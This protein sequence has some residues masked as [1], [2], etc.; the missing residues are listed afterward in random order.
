MNLLHLEDDVS[1]FERSVKPHYEKITGLAFQHA[2]NTE[3]AQLILSQSGIDY[4]V[5]DLSVPV[6]DNGDS[7][8]S[9]GLSFAMFVRNNYPGT[10]IIIL[11]GQSTQKAAQRFE[12]QNTFAVHWDGESKNLV[13][14][15][16]KSDL[17]HVIKLLKYETECLRVL[18]QIELDYDAS[19]LQ[20]SRFQ[21]RVIR[22]FS[23]SN[24]AIAATVHPLT[25][26]LSSAKVLK[27][28]LLNATGK[29]IHLALAKV[30]NFNKADNEKNNYTSHITKLSVGCFPTF[31]N[32]YSAGCGSVKGVFFQFADKYKENYFDSFI[33]GD[34]SSFETISLIKSLF[35]YWKDNTELKNL[36]I[37]EVR[38]I[39]CNDEKFINKAFK[40][41][42]EY[43][44]SIKELELKY[45]NV[46]FCIQHV[47]L[48]GLNILLVE[49]KR[50][51]PLIIDYG[52]V[53][54]AP[55]AYDI[56]TLELSPYFHPYIVEKLKLDLAPLDAWF[57]DSVAPTLGRNP[58]TSR[59]L[60]AWARENAYLKQ[61][62]AACVYAYA[63][64][65]LTYDDTDKRAA[66][67]LIQGVLRVFD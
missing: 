61:D 44:D 51:L 10:P 43:E 7:N 31:I 63:V 6:N 32:E 27:V 5:L 9:H 3:S 14:L 17:N 66:L 48:H 50:S 47:D 16:R 53:Q 33:K 25:G 34:D 36:S 37:G 62:Y 23:F 41:L 64:K 18:D 65:Q 15:R 8:M 11:T 46:N 59:F 35:S 20:L 57:N 60:R 28:G 22:L 2:K 52:D 67:A 26:G 56:V 24:N 19:V 55:A 42:N 13:K 58:E 12:E 40:Y 54:K 30:D 45:V 38:K 49:D 4:V 29:I 1:W 39:V 21:K